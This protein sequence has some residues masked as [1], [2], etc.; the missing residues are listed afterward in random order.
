VEIHQPDTC[1]LTVT[2]EAVSPLPVPTLEQ[3]RAQDTHTQVLTQTPQKKI[4][5]DW[6][7]KED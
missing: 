6:N 1:S 2:T 3:Q 7:K 5:E 4:L